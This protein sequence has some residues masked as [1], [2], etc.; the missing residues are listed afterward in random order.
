MKQ[1]LILPASPCWGGF[2]EKLVQQVKLTLRN[3]L[4]KS[5]L[6][7][8]ELQTIHCENEYLINCTPLVHTSSN[9]VHETLTLFHLMY[10]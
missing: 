10:G 9:N 4:G 5:F 8:E 3:T 7:F 6:T 1:S 2:Y